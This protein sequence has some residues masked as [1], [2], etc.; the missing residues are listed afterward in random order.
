MTNKI[1]WKYGTVRE[2]VRKL[3]IQNGCVTQ[4]LYDLYD[5]FKEQCPNLIYSSYTRMVRKIC[6]ELR[7]E[8]DMTPLKNISKT[9]KGFS[10]IAGLRNWVYEQIIKNDFNK[11]VVY[12]LYNEAKEI[13]N[14]ERT[15]ES[16]ERMVRDVYNQTLKKLKENE[17]K[18]IYNIGV[19]KM[20]VDK[21]KFIKDDL[22]NLEF[23]RMVVLSDLHCGHV[24]GLTPP[25]W[26]FN[27]E[28]ETWGE[29]AR[30]QNESWQW[31]INAVRRVGKKIDILVLNGD[32]IDGRGERSGSTELITADRTKQAS[33]AVDCI[34]EWDAKQIF[35]TRGTPYHSGQA[36][37]FEDLVAERVGGHIEDVLDI[38]VN[39]KTFNFRH[40]I[41]GSSVPYGKATQV[42]KESIWN[43]LYAIY[44]EIPSAD[45]IIRSHVHHMV[46]NQDSLRWSI[47][48]PALQVNSRYGKQQ[49]NGI[50]DFGFIVIDIYTNG[51]ITV[52]PYIA[53]LETQHS[54][55]IEI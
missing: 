48:T 3:A 1:S 49:C 36:E 7:D 24:M 13:F 37:Q 45:V 51:H 40:K 17:S 4:P 14:L 23:K 34:S 15:R 18:I 42:I 19:E 35:M 5:Y 50:T 10:H 2:E 55:V 26:Q 21:I 33:I 22:E 43:A 41:G 46:I 27:P 54:E 28:N 11:S 25:T 47:T 31:Y 38:K 12:D 9:Q 20:K 44:H 39:G 6:S 30:V 32:L 16:Y 52:N 53:K 8:L 29:V